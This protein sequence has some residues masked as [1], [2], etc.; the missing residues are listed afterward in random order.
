MC[1]ELKQQTNQNPNNKYIED[2]SQQKILSDFCFTSGVEIWVHILML[3]P[4]C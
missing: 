2:I 3:I 1:S 4:I